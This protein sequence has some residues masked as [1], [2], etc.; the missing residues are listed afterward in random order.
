MVLNVL[1]IEG[2]PSVGRGLRALVG[3]MPDVVV[4]EISPNG[5]DGLARAVEARPHV[6]LV[7]AELPEAGR[8]LILQLRAWLP[9]TRVVALGMYPRRRAMAL[10]AGAHCFLY[11]D[12]GYDA[13]YAAITGAS[14]D[15]GPLAADGARRAPSATEVSR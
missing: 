3:A 6:V 12:A 5:V 1:I 11:K 8:A 13:L 2:H 10:A 14:G 7:D 4:R 15:P 9:A